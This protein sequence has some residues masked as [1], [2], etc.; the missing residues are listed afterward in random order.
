MCLGHVFCLEFDA[1]SR[2]FHHKVKRLGQSSGK[3]PHT[4]NKS[5][6]HDLPIRKI[7]LHLIKCE[8]VILRLELRY[9]IRPSDDGFFLVVEQIAVFPVIAFQQIDLILGKTQSSTELHIVPDSVVAFRQD[10]CFD[11]DE[12][13]ESDIIGL[14][15]QSIR[16]QLLVE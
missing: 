7:F 11:D 15:L 2:R 13:H 6:F 5:E 4:T 16:A 10:G 9:F 8:V 1:S 3:M 12:L 14:R